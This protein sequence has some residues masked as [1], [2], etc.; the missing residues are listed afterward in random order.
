[1]SA[2]TVHR[3]GRASKA[4]DDYATS[5]DAPVIADRSAECALVELSFEQQNIQRAVE[6]GVGIDDLT[7]PE[8]REVFTAQ[9]AIFRRGQGPDPAAVRRE[10]GPRAQAL[11]LW[12]DENSVEATEVA[13]SVET[14]ASIVMDRARRRHVVEQARAVVDICEAPTSRDPAQLD[15]AID[16]LRSTALASAQSDP[17]NWVSASQLAEPL[18]VTPW[19]VPGLQLGPGRPASIQAYGGGMKSLA[20][21]SL[22]V[23]CAAGVSVFGTF[24]VGRQKSCAWIDHE[25]GLR[26]SQRRFQRLARGREIDL[27]EL[28]IKLS[29]LPRMKL[30]DPR[31]RDAFMRAGDGVELAVLDSF[32]ASTPGVDENDSAIRDYVDVLLEVSERTGVTW[33]VLH[34]CGKTRDGHEDGRQKGRGSSALFDAWGTVFDFAKESDAIR[35]VSMTKC[36][37]EAAGPIAPFFIEVVDVAQEGDPTAGVVVRYRTDEQVRPPKPVTASLETDIERVVGALAREGRSTSIDAIVALAGINLGRGRSAVRTAL[38]R[39]QIERLGTAR[40][41]IFRVCVRT[42][43]PPLD[44]GRPGDGTS[45]VR[46]MDVSDV[47]RTSSGRRTSSQREGALHG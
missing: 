35:R 17:W 47:E 9:L 21:A 28:P 39:G 46:G 15:R 20:A 33:V 8:L 41:P 44:A 16:E 36:H 12:L 18:P 34:H 6:L 31:A 42:P 25:M 5:N 29:A 22:V 3:A 45:S 23:A 27:R 11:E 13:G 7:V 37:P 10:L 19:V 24:P 2:R 32:R 1:M 4:P 38:S 40:D 43:I 30:T 14:F 26:A